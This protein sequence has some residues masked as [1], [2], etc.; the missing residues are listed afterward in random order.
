MLM[1]GIWSTGC[2]VDDRGAEAD[3]GVRHEECGVLVDEV[4]SYQNCWQCAGSGPS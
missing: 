1:S 3:G 4:S 2:G